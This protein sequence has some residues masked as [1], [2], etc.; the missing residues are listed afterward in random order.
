MR[1]DTTGMGKDTNIE[2]NT[3]PIE[4]IEGDKKVEEVKFKDGTTLKTEGVFI[5]AGSAGSLEFAKKLGIFTRK[6]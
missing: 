5:A 4:A 3:N 1:I 2:I 6:R